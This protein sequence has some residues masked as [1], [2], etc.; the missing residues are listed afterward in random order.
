MYLC[1]TKTVIPNI[2]SIANN[3]ADF[4]SFLRQYRPA[5]RYKHPCMGL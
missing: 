3:R 1:D 4:L 5:A 2:M